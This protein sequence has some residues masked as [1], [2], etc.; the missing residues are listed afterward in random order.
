[1]YYVFPRE[2]YVFPGEYAVFPREYC[3]SE[4][5]TPVPQSGT[6]VRP[7]DSM[8]F[9]WNIMESGPDPDG[10]GLPL[11]FWAGLQE[12]FGILRNLPEF[13]RREI[14]P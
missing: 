14:G 10:Q 4:R 7:P 3:I 13:R 12:F 2:Y 9:R 1:M 6:G 11:G 8:I 5:R